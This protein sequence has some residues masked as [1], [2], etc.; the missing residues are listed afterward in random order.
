MTDE[1]KCLELLRHADSSGHK[2]VAA[3]AQRINQCYLEVASI[4]QKQRA[5]L[6]ISEDATAEEVERCDGVVLVG[7]ISIE[8]RWTSCLANMQAIARGE[9]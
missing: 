3:M 6:N 9:T 8:S 7:D 2:G 1:E 4:L 5:A